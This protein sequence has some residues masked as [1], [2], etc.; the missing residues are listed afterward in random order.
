MDF[1]EVVDQDQYQH[2]A[3]IDVEAQFLV[4]Q[5]REQPHVPSVLRIGFPPGT[6]GDIAL[7]LDR[8]ETVGQQQKIE[9]MA[10]SLAVAHEC[11]LAPE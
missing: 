11:P 4:Q 2:M 3:K 5:E 8:L 10:K 7:A 9:N 6:V 1:H